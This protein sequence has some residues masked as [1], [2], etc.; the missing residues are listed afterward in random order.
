M[1]GSPAYYSTD[2]DNCED[3]QE[4]ENYSHHNS[5]DAANAT[6]ICFWWCCLSCVRVCVCVCVEYGG[7][8]VVYLQKFVG[9]PTQTP[10]LT[11]IPGRQVVHITSC[12]FAE[13]V[14]QL[15]I[16][17]SQATVFNK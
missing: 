8:V 17:S 5:N 4:K 16:T 3:K 15:P 9:I 10:F 7:G 13:H 11:I 2:N 12:P 1:V 14:E 6:K